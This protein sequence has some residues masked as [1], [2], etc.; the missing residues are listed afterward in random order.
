MKKIVIFISG[1]GSNMEAI[2]KEIESG[3]LKDT[4]EIVLVF[5]NKPDAPGLKKA[6]EK[7]IKITS[8]NSK[9]KNRKEYDIELIELLSEYDFDYII[10]AGY[11]RILSENFVNT[12]KKRIINIHPADTKKHQGLHAYEWAFENNLDET[13]ITVH[14]VDAGVD[15]GE[16]IAQTK[17]DLKGAESLNEVER[18]G[19]VAEHTFYSETLYNIFKQK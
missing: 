17:V 7:G 8:I 15:T 3:I 11:M 13:V 4:A 18:R 10:L 14:Y 2:I 6:E 9:G 19:L 16:I 12:F 1:R 5:S